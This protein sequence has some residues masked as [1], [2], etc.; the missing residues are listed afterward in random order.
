MKGGHEGCTL[1]PSGQVGRAKVG[2]HIDPA[3]LGQQRRVIHLQCVAYPGGVS[4]AE[5]LRSVPD[6]LAVGT[7]GPNVCA[8]Q[9]QAFGML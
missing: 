6:G 9:A 3:E 7:N 4:A 1:T 2:H 5:L 8:R